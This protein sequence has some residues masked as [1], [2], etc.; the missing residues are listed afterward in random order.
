M[1]SIRHCRVALVTGS[2]EGGLTGIQYTID[3]EKVKE[4]KNK[5]LANK[6]TDRQIDVDE[7]WFLLTY[8]GWCWSYCP[9]FLV[10]RG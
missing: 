5:E 3:R 1:D 4:I 10:S 7:E 8:E 9:V 2:S 6:N